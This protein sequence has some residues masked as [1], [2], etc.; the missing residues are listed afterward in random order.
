MEKEQILQRIGLGAVA[1][2]IGTAAIQAV[3]TANQKAAPQSASAVRQEVSGQPSR[4]QPMAGHES[5]TEILKS[6][7]ASMLSA[8]FGST[9]AAVYSAFHEEPKIL[10]DGALLGTGIWAVNQF[11]GSEASRTKKRTAL[12]TALSLGQYALFGIATVGAYRRLRRRV[13]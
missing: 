3:R 7:A 10:V 8:S 12:K 4:G 11:T 9:G 5:T 13:A 2:L 6:A 1:G